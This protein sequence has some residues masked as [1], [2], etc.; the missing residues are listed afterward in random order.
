MP[1]NFLTPSQRENFGCYVGTPASETLE[2]YFYLSDTDHAWIT[3]KHGNHNQLGFSLQLT[4]VRYLGTFLD[5]P[6][7]APQNVIDTLCKQLQIKDS[8]CLAVYGRQRWQHITE[9]STREGYRNF[10]DPT[11]GFRL[12]RWLYAQCWTGTE[13]PGALFERATSW[14][15]T[16]KVLLPGASVLERFVS[17]LRQRVDNRICRLLGHSISAEKKKQLESMLLVPEGS[18][19]SV[20]D[21]LR[22][23]PV[24]VSVPAL[25]RTLER[26]Q[27][28]RELG[29]EPA[30]VSA[31]PPS[32]IAALARIANTAKVTAVANL[33]PARRLATLVA[34]IHILEATALDDALEVFEMLVQELFSKARKA[35]REARIRTLKDLDAAAGTL[36]EACRIVLDTTFSDQNLRTS[37]FAHIPRQELTKALAD[38]NALVRPP[39]DVFFRALDQHYPRVRRFLPALLKHVTFIATPAGAPVHEA[40]AYLAEHGQKIP[41]S[42]KPPLA[43]VKKAWERHV[44]NRNGGVDGRAYTFCVLDRLRD[45]LRR[46]DVFVSPSWRYADPRSGLFAGSEWEAIRPIVCRSLG[47]SADAAP[48][49]AALAEEL[50]KTYRHVAA[51]LPD[52]PA[53]TIERVEGRDEICLSALDKI[54]DPPSL[55]ALRHEID[56]RMPRVEL[57]EIMLEIAVRTGFT[58]AFTHITDRKARADEMMVSI[59]AALMGEAMNIGVE[60]LAN[61]DISALRRDRLSWVLQNYIRSETITP[62]NAMLVAEQNRIELARVA[63]G[64]GEVASADGIRFVVPLRTVH[65]GPNPEYFGLGKGMTFYNMMSNQF[66]GLNGIPVAGTLRDSL[67]LLAVVLEQ[68]TELQPFQI[69]TDEGAYSDIIFGLFRLLGFRFCPRFA[70]IGSARFW[71]INP[72]ADYGP[73]D[74]I[75]RNRINLSLITSQWDDMLRLAGSLKMGRVPATGIMRTLQVGDR[76]TSLANAIAEFGR[77]DKTLH[78]LTTMDDEA[79]RRSTLIQL[80]RHESRHSLSR[81]VFHGKRG[82]LRKRYREGQEDQLGALGLVVNIIVLWNTIYMD[83]ALKQLRKEGYSV[84]DEDVARLSPTIRKHIN[85]MGKYPFVMPEAVAKGELRPLRN[86]FD[87]HS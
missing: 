44:L 42:A 66:T 19:S 40:C 53:V 35:D 22:S 73:L 15:L 85:L 13:R 54:D 18:R 46:R 17:R 59:C 84:R 78:M 77:I 30:V 68:Q 82:E 36:A 47:Y 49:L 29:I 83:A 38:V 51:R 7:K 21:Q 86:P 24:M 48:V 16:N 76:Q 70:D 26:L 31:I 50:D 27:K 34:F 43:I 79:K 20:L 11:V 1:V 41:T 5:T 72:K 56:K 71:R 55:T 87:E 39:D 81:A 33:P 10:S 2:R 6:I 61:P 3:S 74:T 45:A 60:P 4:T 64:G 8:G 52:N 23:G 80:N 12:T 75:A 65:A 14:L 57:S 9:I 58:K 62:G 69:M 25:L 63:W 37:L 32:R 67:V 28:V